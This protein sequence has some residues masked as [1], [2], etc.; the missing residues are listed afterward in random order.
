MQNTHQTH[1]EDYILTGDFRAL[2]AILGDFHL[3][4]KIDGSPAVVF[5]TNPANGKWFVST[6]SAFNKIKIKLCHS[7][8]EIDSHFENV[9]VANILHACF[10][11]LP[12]TN[13]ILQGD[14]IGFSDSD[15]YTP[16]VITY[17]FP[18]IVSQ[19]IIISVHTEYVT[20]NE[21]KNAYMIGPASHFESN[22]SVL[23]VNNDASL[24]AE[25]DDFA[26]VIGFIKQMATTVKFATPE[27]AKKIQKQINTAIRENREIQPD[28]FDNSDL[29]S[30]W[31]VAESVKLD[32]L[33]FC[34]A[35][36]AP[37]SYLNGERIHHEGF[38]L[39]NDEV[40]VKFV[41]RFVFSRSN[42]LQNK[43][44]I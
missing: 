1:F 38:V 39:R 25:R 5:G 21:L 20:E 44:S 11:Y 28:E 37:D 40:L 23:F 27:E 12:R 36:H 29:I 4:T 15:E 35:N 8:Q 33:H 24:I 31:K 43:Y 10:D 42:F 26:E 6:K 34:R 30:L 2:N 14:F 13:K 18:E 9:Q 41:N 22:D 16:N 32:F 3:S 19:K 7:H 17:K